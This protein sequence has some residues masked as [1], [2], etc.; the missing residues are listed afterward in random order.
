MAKEIR[1]ITNIFFIIVFV[2]LEKIK[3]LYE[4]G[5]TQ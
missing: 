5:R 1:S 2:N 3:L 4:I